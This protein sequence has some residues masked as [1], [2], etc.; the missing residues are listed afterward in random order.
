MSCPPDFTIAAISGSQFRVHTVHCGDHYG[1]NGALRHLKVDPLIEF[2]DLANTETF[3]P[4]GQFITRHYA[5]TLAHHPA[6]AILCLDRDV[7]AWT[8]HGAA[9]EIVIAHARDL[10]GTATSDRCDCL[11]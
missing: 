2:F 9:L 6:S 1:E 5:S 4:Q 8:I 3:G 10:H 7:P 11:P